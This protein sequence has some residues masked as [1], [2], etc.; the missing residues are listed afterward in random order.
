[1]QQKHSDIV[2][3]PDWFFVPQDF[4][5]C[6]DDLPVERKSVL[7]HL[8]MVEEDA[9]SYLSGMIDDL[10]V[11]SREKAQPSASYSVYAGPVFIRE[12]DGMLLED[13]LFRLGKLVSSFLGKSEHIA[14]FA[15]SCGPE[16]EHFS[17]KLIQDK[18]TLEGYL[19]DLIAS[20]LAESIAEKIHDEIAKHAARA[21]LLITNRYSP[22]YCNWPVS[23]QQALFSLLE[24]H[25]CGITVTPSSL[26]MPVKSVSGIVG[27]GRNVKKMGYKCR[28]CADE[29]CLMRGK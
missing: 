12:E 7:K 15:A 21:Q 18:H 22:G 29:K 9:D 26:M 5:F 1:M 2:A 3:V 27:I 16:V 19:V 14:V 28:Y 17:K 6:P 8:G 25:N 23:D 24:G 4:A 20:E 13:R 11:Q 10:T